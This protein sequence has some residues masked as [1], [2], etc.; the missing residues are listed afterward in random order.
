MKKAFP[1]L[2][3]CIAL[4]GES[5]KPSS[6]RDSAQGGSTQLNRDSAQWFTPCQCG[7][8]VLVSEVQHRQFGTPVI[9][10]EVQGHFT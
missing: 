1:V 10:S 8:P 4:W 2:L 6:R 5:A 3:V 9:V 7:T